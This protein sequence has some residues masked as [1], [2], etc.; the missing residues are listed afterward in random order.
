MTDLQ[1]LRILLSTEPT[2]VCRPLIEG[3]LY[4]AVARDIDDHL[5][6]LEAADLVDLGVDADTA[7]D[8]AY[9]LLE[10][11]TEPSDLRPTDTEPDVWFAVSGDGLA[12]SRLALLPQLVVPMPLGGIV[13]AIPAHNQLLVM[14][15]DSARALDALQ[16]LA[17]T[18]SAAADDPDNLLSDQLYWND[19]TRWVPVPVHHGD[20]DITVLPPRGFVETMNR[21]AAMDLVSVAGEA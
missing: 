1:R 15:V 6:L 14:F 19:G 8:T 5:H 20:D 18:V 7:F 2:D 17:S 9:A 13:A 16:V 3:H 10:R 4:L 12:A 21:V 11:T